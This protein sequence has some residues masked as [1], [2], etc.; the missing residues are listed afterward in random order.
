M[1]SKTL[2]KR[3]A[4]LISIGFTLAS[5]AFLSFSL[6]RQFDAIRVIR[7]EATDFLAGVAATGLSL[8]FFLLLAFSWAFMLEEGIP[9]RRYVSLAVSVYARTSVLKYV[10]GNVFHYIG[11]NLAGHVHGPS[12]LRLASATF[13]EI[14]YSL[15]S[16]VLL[17]SIVF[18]IVSGPL[19]Q[20]VFRVSAGATLII[21][22]A[23]LFRPQFVTRLLNIL[24]IPIPD[25]KLFENA[26]L[27]LVCSLAAFIAAMASAGILSLSILPLEVSVMSAAAYFV[28]AWLAGFIIPGAPGGL[29]VREAILVV[30]LTPV[31]GEAEAL[32]FALAMRLA[33]T[34][35]DVLLFCVGSILEAKISGQPVSDGA[36]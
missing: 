33:T 4:S 23:F 35:G 18:S 2:L 9:R 22:L 13:L 11:R 5:L 8:I 34:V 30:L 16:T 26:G 3:L 25:I 19:P 27:A 28:V 32:A 14:F 6:Y 24:P 31:A 10:P 1:P 15:I 21:A 36:N 7:W 12:H 20:I 29:G 17:S